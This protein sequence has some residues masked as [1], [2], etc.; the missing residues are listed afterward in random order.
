VHTLDISIAATIVALDS[1]DI[2]ITVVKLP[3]FLD[4]LI[5]VL[6]PDLTDFLVLQ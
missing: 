5:E 4:I 6:T 2:H 3:D 1:L